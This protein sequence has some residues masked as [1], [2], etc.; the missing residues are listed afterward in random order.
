MSIN[1]LSPKTVFGVIVG[2]LL[3][4][5]A[6]G[7]YLYRPA[8]DGYVGGHWNAMMG[9]IHHQQGEFAFSRYEKEHQTDQ[10][11][12]SQRE[13]FHQAFLGVAEKPS[14]ET[15]LKLGVAQYS[16]N[17][18][19]SAESSFLEAQKVAPHASNVLWNLVQTEI[20]LKK[21]SEAERWAKFSIDGEPWNHI[22]D[23]YLQLGD[24]YENYITDKKDQAPVI[25]GQGW[26]N[27]NDVQFLQKLIGYWKTKD[28]ARAVP[29]YEEIIRHLTPGP[30]RD[31]FVAELAQIKSKLPK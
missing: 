29:Y 15:W 8:I 12:A 3:L 23:G 5:A 1:F 22:A 31:A 17:D 26:Q 9:T 2:L 6:G 16:I 30:T 11:F 13:E 28:P 27:T 24:L 18:F 19:A 25:Y 10:A 7:Y 14:A 20:Q 21:F 4:A